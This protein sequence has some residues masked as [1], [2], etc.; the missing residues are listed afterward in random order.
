[1]DRSKAIELVKG[2]I[3]VSFADHGDWITITDQSG[4]TALAGE[5]QRVRFENERRDWELWV[6][7][8]SDSGW[9]RPEV[10]VA[11]LIKPGHHIDPQALRIEVAE[12]IVDAGLGWMI[13]PALDDREPA[14]LS[15]CDFE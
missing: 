10:E 12:K 13:D 1:M 2:R 15:D 11:G 5:I 8:S 14:D 4:E 6:P 9:V 7:D 3:T